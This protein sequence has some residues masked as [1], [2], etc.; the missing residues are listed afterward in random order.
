MKIFLLLIIM[1]FFAGLGYLF[2]AR[3]KREIA[4]YD[5]LFDFAEFCKS[6]ISLFQNNLVNIID[7]YII[8]H[9]NKNA[10]F[11][12]IFAKKAYIYQISKENIEK[13]IQNKK[14]SE[15]V[16][17]F[18]TGLGGSDYEF[19]RKRIDEFLDFIKTKREKEFEVLLKNADLKF[20]LFL[21]IGAV[22]CIVV[23]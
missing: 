21:A 14:D 17:S 7:N 23:W 8:M 11:D 6:N 18:L 1:T 15:T 20:K 2:K 5:F 9:K 3:Q 10:N 19:E 16:F 22:V 4:F 13:L 12:K